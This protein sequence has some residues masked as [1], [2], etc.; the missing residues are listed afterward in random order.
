MAFR[1]QSF[2]CNICGHVSKYAR[3]IKK[4]IKIVHEKNTANTAN[5]ANIANTTH[6]ANIGN[7]ANIANTSNTANTANT[8]CAIVPYNTI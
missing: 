5:T 3:D 7:T 8:A 1:K 6:I 4:H 2:T